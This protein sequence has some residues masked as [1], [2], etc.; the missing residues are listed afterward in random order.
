MGTSVTDPNDIVTFDE[1]EPT[2]QERWRETVEQSTPWSRLTSLIDVSPAGGLRAPPLFER[3]Q[4]R[5]GT[6]GTIAPWSVGQEY[7]LAQPE[8]V[9]EALA[10]DRVFGLGAAWIRLAS[11]VG[12]EAEA[13]SSGTVVTGPEHLA[14][15]LQAAQDVPVFLDAGASGA[16]VVSW[17]L[18]AHTHPQTLRGGVLCDPLGALAEHGGLGQSVHEA[19][20]QVSMAADKVAGVAPALRIAMA[21]GTPYH[22]A[23][24]SPSVELGAI[25]ATLI[26]TLRHVVDN[27]QGPAA[28]WP[29]LVLRTSAECDVFVGIAKVR[30]LRWLAQQVAAQF[31][32]ENVPA[33]VAVRS[34]WRDRTRHDPWVNMLR[35]TTE[36]FAAATGGADEITVLP[37]TEA[38]GPGDDDARRWAINTA[39]MLRDESHVAAVV[40]P[41]AGS[42]YVEFLT[43]S[44]AQRAWAWVQGIE[45]EGGMANALQE[46]RV[47][48][49]VRA[50]RE[51]GT[52]ALATGRAAL[53]GVSV[54]PQLDETSPPVVEDAAS[55]DLGS[56]DEAVVRVP[57]MERAR[58][59]EPFE[60]LRDA[61]DK[62][63]D[64]HGY[65]PRAQ[66]FTLGELRE[67]RARLDFARAAV[68]VGGFEPQVL[69]TTDDVVPA[70]VVL[71]ASDERLEAEGT[72]SIEALRKA[73][74]KAVWAACAPRD[75]LGAD[76]HLHLRMDVPAVMNT[77]HD[78]LGVGR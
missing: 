21:S 16:K 46:G 70:L 20:C 72:A 23:G 26:E 76:G 15:I 63:R 22:D 53:T 30:A 78:V 69:N 56:M 3:A 28:L 33:H 57:T 12:V 55:T 62:H 29:R 49:D 65:R 11:D 52:K 7:A 32:I 67:H 54:F 13:R 4:R 48:A 60:R 43:E 74:A 35:A 24:A 10:A 34:S 18:E 77:L 38:I 68:M 19:L 40:D 59:A 47:Q 73:G 8:S 37:F 42:G 6:R 9:A 5:A 64:L 2:S 44:L 39:N 27:G 41:G 61:S 45:R 25:I 17:L 75:E 66:L 31:G 51:A 1:F 71:V 14:T 58:M 36:T 50:C